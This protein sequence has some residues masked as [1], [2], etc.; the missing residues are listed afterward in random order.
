[1]Q[2]SRKRSF[3]TI[4]SVT[5][6]REACSDAP[7][8]TCGTDRLRAEVRSRGTDTNG[9]FRADLLACLREMGVRTIDSRTPIPFH[10]DNRSRDPT[11][12]FLGHQA[13]HSETRPQQL[14]ISN[15]DT[16][17]PLIGGNFETGVVTIHS[18]IRLGDSTG[19]KHDTPGEVG[20]VR[21]KGNELFMLREFDGQKRWYRLAFDFPLSP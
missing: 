21:R 12:L 10:P 1:M 16:P 6:P 9:M 3:R 17:T 14:V 19:L 4:S 7:I 15:C 20:D 5:T 8:E 11:C 13:G 2:G 18:C